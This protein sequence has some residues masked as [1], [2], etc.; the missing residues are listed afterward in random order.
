M[1]HYNFLLLLLAISISAVASAKPFGNKLDAY[2]LQKLSSLAQSDKNVVTLAEIQDFPFRRI[3]DKI[4]VS[5]LFELDDRG[6][7]EEL[8]NFGVKVNSIAGNIVAVEL[9]VNRLE[10]ILSLDFVLRASVQRKYKF[11]LDSSRKSI[12][13]DLVHQGISLPSKFDGKG[14]IVG[15]FDTG[16]DWQHPDFSDENGTRILYLWD[17]SDQSGIGQPAGYDWGR[18]YTKEQIDNFPESVLEKDYIGH[19]THV[20]GI[21]AGNGR[22]K[23]NFT[24]IAPKADMIIVKGLRPSESGV[25]DVDIIAG[26]NY[27]FQKANQI[28]KPCVINLS[29]GT[30]LGPH[31]GE[32]LQSKALSNLVQ[33]KA[34]Q[35]IVAAAGNYAG[36]QIH[37]GGN[38]IGNGRNELVIFPFNICNALPSMCPDLP[39]YFLIGADIWSDPGVIDSVYVGIYSRLNYEFISEIGFSVEDGTKL[40]QMF[41]L[42]NQLAGIISFSFASTTSADNALIFIANVGDT[43]IQ[44]GNYIWSVVLTTKK[45]GRIDSWA[46]IPI[47]SQTPFPSRFERFPSDNRMSIGSPASGKNIISVGSYNSK[48]KFVNIQGNEIDSSNSYAL[49]DISAFSSRGPTRDGRIV[50]TVLAP[51]AFVFSAMSGTMLPEKVDLTF[52]EPSGMYVGMLGTSMAAPHVAGAVALLLQ[53]NPQLDFSQVAELL[54]SSATTDIYTGNT[55]NNDAGWGKLDVLRLLQLVTSVDTPEEAD[56][57]IEVIPNPTLSKVRVGS[58]F[59]VTRLEVLNLLG[60]KVSE[61]NGTNELDLSGFP[62]GVYIVAIYTPVGKY[63]RMVIKL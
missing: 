1:K 21:A 38:A 51:G 32:D 2:S 17:M 35:I 8:A 4:F 47:G 62:S 41:D 14:V 46:S 29:V 48:N 36:L 12:K 28:G 37:S 33:G 53:Q 24:G 23:E 16:I 26:C 22:G 6:S 40:V 56:Y 19:G 58:L 43:S 5:M 13:A 57:S 25:T 49:N 55:P 15:I 54:K 9:P 60:C 61:C 34:G 31:D 18:E 42:S 39:N 59:E 11:N 10:E 30:A 3:S 45:S 63:H 20:A 7:V 50:P 27:I 44:V 52:V